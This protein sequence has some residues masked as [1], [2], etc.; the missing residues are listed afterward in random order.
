MR[1]QE[2]TDE[3]WQKLSKIPPLIKQTMTL[4][5]TLLIGYQPLPYKNLVNFFRMVIHA[6]PPPTQHDMDFVLDEIERCG[7]NLEQ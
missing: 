5:G 6:V 3:F 2:K 7:S 4:E 1:G